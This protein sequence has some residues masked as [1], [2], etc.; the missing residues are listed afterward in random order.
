MVIYIEGGG[1][2]RLNAELREGFNALFK[3]AGLER[4]MPKVVACGSRNEAY[5][6]FKKAFEARNNEE[7]VLLL[8]DSEE[9]LGPN[10]SKWEH[11]RGKEQKEKIE[12][13]TDDNLFFMTVVMESWFLADVD[14]LKKFFGKGFDSKKLPQNPSYEE[15]SKKDLY[16]GLK[17]AT[18]N[19][20]KGEYNKGKHSFKILSFLDVRKVR[21][22]G[23]QAKEFFNCLDENMT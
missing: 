19:S 14:G 11:L 13:A 8:I 9:L 17:K 7:L 22:H 18:K 5:L 16:E 3:N 4:K 15:I 6:D 1:N 2:Q 21:N 23:K 10:Q 20:V 12:G